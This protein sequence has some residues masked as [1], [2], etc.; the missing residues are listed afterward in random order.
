MVVWQPA[1]GELRRRGGGTKGTIQKRRLRREIPAASGA[2]LNARQ[3][4]RTLA[5]ASGAPA[6][7]ELVARMDQRRGGTLLLLGGGVPLCDGEGYEH[8]TDIT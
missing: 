3:R 7:V 6:H 5:L 2:G 4:R 8:D 1:R